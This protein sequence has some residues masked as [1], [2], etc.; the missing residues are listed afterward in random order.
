MP[1]V[2]TLFLGAHMLV[3]VLALL[4]TLAWFFSAR[5]SPRPIH[6]LG[7]LSAL[8]LLVILCLRWQEGGHIP[9]A[10]GLE[11]AL[12]LT[13]TVVLMGIFITYKEDIPVLGF[14][15]WPLVILLNGWMLSLDT[16]VTAPAPALRSVWLTVHV[17]TAV[18]AYAAFALSFAAS[19]LVLLN[20]EHP[21]LKN[22]DE[23]DTLAGRVVL[24]GMPFQTL[25][26]ILGAI[27]AEEA[28]GTY[29]SWD[30]KEVWALITW[31]IYAL[32][33]HVRLRGVTPRLA[34]LV[35]VVA[36]FTMLFTFFGVSYLLPGMHSYL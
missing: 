27:W 30:A 26:I 17:S 32:Y 13:L 16:T 8:L 23:A 9:M 28:W 12:W 14:I 31:I 15:T 4:F 34:A 3:A 21:K 1:N 24:W 35:N 7:A 10:N 11:F 20:K 33:L 19:L 22:S 18:V 6:G 2:Y 25:T 5:L 36:F 29:W